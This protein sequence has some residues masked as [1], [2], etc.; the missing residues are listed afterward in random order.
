MMSA[1]YSSEAKSDRELDASPAQGCRPGD[2]LSAE[3][4]VRRILRTGKDALDAPLLGSLRQARAAHSGDP[5][6]TA[7]LDCVLDKDEGRYDYRSYLALDVL[8]AVFPGSGAPFPARRLRR[9][10]MADVVAFESETARGIG[11][12][13]LP[14][15]R[16]SPA[17]TARRITKAQRLSAEWDDVEPLPA[18]PNDR[19]GR[20]L[21]CSVLPVSPQHDEYLFIRVLQAYEITFLAMGVELQDALDASHTHDILG[22]TAHINA[23]AT[24]L[25][26]TSGLFSLLATMRPES[27]QAFRAQTD[28]SSAIQS[29]A[30]KSLELLCGLPTPE[31]LDSPAFRSVPGIRERALDPSPPDSLAAW[32]LRV[33]PRLSEKQQ[34][35]V[36]TA[37]DRL[38]KAHQKWKRT[39]LSL[40]RTMIG[41][42]AGT[43]DTDGV[44]YLRR[45]LDNRLFWE[46]GD[47]CPARAAHTGDTPGR[48]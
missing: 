26:R 31:R 25:E 18:P 20:I 43:G 15:G 1:T 32:Y 13:R 36:D 4:V 21:A 34:E 2:P 35:A 10:L 37:L 5:W 33:Y 3:G 14:L 12:D 16:P 38:E 44:D 41:D 30:Y 24:E 45:T 22:A 47:R 27:F 48:S 8:N 17:T 19:A 11:D 29:R 40:A 42:A 46:I 28:G 39:H 23:A 6:I 9:L 7:L